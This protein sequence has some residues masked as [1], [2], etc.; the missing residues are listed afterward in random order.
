MDS[1]TPRSGGRYCT[2][3]RSAGA[4]ASAMLLRRGGSGGGA[5]GGDRGPWDMLPTGGAEGLNASMRR[6]GSAASAT[7]ASSETPATPEE[8]LALRMYHNLR[9]HVLA[10]AGIALVRTRTPPSPALT[11]GSHAADSATPASADSR[12]LASPRVAS[13]AS[14]RPNRLEPAC[15][16][17]CGRQAFYAQ[18]SKDKATS[19]ADVPGTPRWEKALTRVGMLQLPM[20]ALAMAAFELRHRLPSALR[21]KCTASFAAGVIVLVEFVFSL[22]ASVVGLAGFVTR[23]AANC[24]SAGDSVAE[25]LVVALATVQ[26]MRGIRNVIYQA[27]AAGRRRA[28]CSLPSLL[29]DETPPSACCRL[30]PHRCRLRRR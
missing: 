27:R 22:V 30:A 17:C 19:G 18:Y 28:R 24:P 14:V 13:R 16:V 4:A 29:S 5:G 11:R 9:V 6:R 12:R 25:C 15:N 7:T 8:V 23:P 21:V 20:Q 1:A 2:R 3:G 10:A 26:P